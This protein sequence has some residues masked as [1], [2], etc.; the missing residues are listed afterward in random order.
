MLEYGEVT[1]E[2]IEEVK[3]YVK[4]ILCH[5]C[6]SKV[7]AKTGWEVSNSFAGDCFKESVKKAED[8]VSVEVSFC[9]QYEKGFKCTSGLLLAGL[10]GEGIQAGPGVEA[11]ASLK[12]GCEEWKIGG[13]SDPGGSEFQ[14]GDK[15]VKANSG[16]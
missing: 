9:D 10:M 13:K 4:S 1:E 8:G 15:K 7:E 16:E 3:E 6:V 2:M 5:S 11:A 12:V 14:V